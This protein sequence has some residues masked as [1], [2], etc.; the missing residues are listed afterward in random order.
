MYDDIV[1][2]GESNEEFKESTGWLRRLMKRYGLSFR[3]KTSVTQKDAD[4]PIDKLLSFALPVHRLAM[5]HP[6]DVAD[7]IAMD[8]TPVWADMASATTVDDTG[9]KT[10]TVKTTGHKKTR[11]SVWLAAKA[12]GTK[13]PPFIVFKGAKRK[14]AAIDKEIKNCCIASS[15]NAWINTELTHT[16]VKKVLGTFAFRRRYLVWD[17]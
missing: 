5:K 14:T 13:L 17:S 10:V 12:D 15:P 7:I 1:K 11:V 2:E 6:Y 16:W 4:Q 8:E 3:Q 9:K